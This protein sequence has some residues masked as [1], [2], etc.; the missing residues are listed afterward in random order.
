MSD[1]PL[2]QRIQMPGETFRLPSGGLFYEKGI[3]SEKVVDGEIHVFPMTGIDEITL[4]TPD[5]LFSGNAV[6]QVFS[7][8]IPDVLQPGK[9]LAKDVD[10]LIICLRKVSFGSEMDLTYTH[11]REK[12]KEHNYR[13]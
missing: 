11:F 10:F 4:K 7:R 9:L 6:K 12:A 13:V 3:L 8:C 1:N 2:L 5:L